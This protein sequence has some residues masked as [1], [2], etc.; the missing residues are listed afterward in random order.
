MEDHNLHY[1]HGMPSE[2]STD[3][4][5]KLVDENPKNYINDQKNF[6]GQFITDLKNRLLYINYD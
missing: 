1:R 2:I 4:I 3:R 6:N 5:K